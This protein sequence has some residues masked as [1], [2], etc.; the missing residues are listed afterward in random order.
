M[1]TNGKEPDNGRCVINVLIHVDETMIMKTRDH[2]VVLKNKIN[3]KIKISA[4]RL[5]VVQCSTCS[6]L[7]RITLRGRSTT[8]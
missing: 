5:S 8:L 1:G 2:I 7:H 6:S 3:E 4:R